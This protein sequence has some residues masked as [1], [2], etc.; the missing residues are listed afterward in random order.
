MDR[1]HDIE[2]VNLIDGLQPR[3]FVTEIDDRFQPRP[4]QVILTAADFFF[5]K[6]RGRDL[7]PGK[8]QEPQIESIKT[9]CRRS[10]SGS[11]R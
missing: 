11:L 10:D 3:Q 9:R 8:A 1:H 7:F 6:Q 5:A 4:V 2:Q